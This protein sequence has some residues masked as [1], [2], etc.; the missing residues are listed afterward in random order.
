MTWALRLIVLSPFDN[1]A[2]RSAV[3]LADLLGLYFACFIVKTPL[4]S[5]NL[6]TAVIPLLDYCAVF[7]TR[8][9]IHNIKVVERVQKRFLYKLFKRC[10]PGVVIPSYT[11]RLRLFSFESLEQRYEKLDLV[12]LYKIL[13]HSLHAPGWAI[14][15]SPRHPKLIK[16]PSFYFII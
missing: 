12:T 4:C 3:K 5:S 14:H 13:T 16:F 6:L 11:E 9:S 1:T 15:F 10:Y 8:T 2:R 7:Y